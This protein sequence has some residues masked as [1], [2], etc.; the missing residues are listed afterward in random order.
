MARAL[1]SD[2]GSPRRGQAKARALAEWRSAKERF[3]GAAWIIRWAPSTC[4]SKAAPCRAEPTFAPFA[5]GLAA[6]HPDF[7]QDLFCR[8]P[9]LS[10]RRD[11]AQR[12]PPNSRSTA[13]SCQSAPAIGNGDG[14]DHMVEC[15]GGTGQN[16]R[17]PVQP[18]DATASLA[19]AA[20]RRAAPASREG[21]AFG[22]HGND[23][24]RRCACAGCDDRQC[25]EVEIT[26]DPGRAKGSYR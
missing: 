10:D 22:I 9:G 8:R 25:A 6:R 1:L 19:K 11:F 26:K 20:A 12:L 4:A 3:G 13:R 5:S 17:P 7:N 24:P 16:A 23:T 21:S 15:L 14:Q 2:R 18:W